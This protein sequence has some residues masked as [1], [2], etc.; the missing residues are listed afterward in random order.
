MSVFEVLDEPWPDGG[1]PSDSRENAAI[2]SSM[3][4]SNVVF[5]SRLDDL[6]NRGMWVT[7]EIGPGGIRAGYARGNACGG[8]AVS[9]GQGF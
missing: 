9:N 2:H 8:L 6:V 3:S 1:E 5:G 4:Q 7:K